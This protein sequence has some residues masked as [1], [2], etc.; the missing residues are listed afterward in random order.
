M[1]LLTNLAKKVFTMRGLVASC[2]LLLTM[3]G[4]GCGRP[5]IPQT[6]N[7]Q[8]VTDVQGTPAASL[9]APHFSSGDWPGWRGLNH[10]G[11]ASAS[12]V[13]T[14]WTETENV[15]W[16]SK[17][18]GRGHSSPIILGDRIYLETADDA[19]QKQSVLAVNRANG[20][21]IWQTVIFQGGFEQ[22]MHNENTQASS[23]LASDGE[24]LFALF[25]NDRRIWCSALTLEGEELWRQEVGG[26][27]SRFGYSASP[28]VYQSLVILAADHEEGGFIAG[29][30]RSTGHI[31]WRRKR[32]NNASYASPR[33]VTLNGRDQAVICGCQKVISYDPLTGEELW[34]VNGPTESTVGTPVVADD[35]VIVSGGYPGAETLAVDGTGKV[36][37]RA[38]EKC[39]VPSLLAANGFLY[40]MQDDGIARCLNATNGQE[41]WK[42]RVGGKFRASPLL[43][44]DNIYVTDMSGKT[45]V[46]KADP[47][48]FELV[49]ENQLGNEGFA[50]PAVSQNQLFL[51]VSSDA[52]GRRE[53]L[54][55]CLANP[56]R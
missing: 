38:K 37:W 18:P 23:T 48:G 46:F 55:Y 29:L 5:P 33:V 15:V 1:V 52:G 22:A 17:L 31:V 50:S 7:I 28:V 56:A 8:V 16:K 20:K 2:T 12:A 41:T 14:N 32:P 53:D 36:L 43:V 13:P 3:C 35:A 54:L 26:F 42:H 4:F 6:T 45:T 39:Y 49:A 24:R 27:R 19:A 44:G 34:S 51:R 47:K 11:I 9:P 40:L 21:W 10:D 30:D 25:L